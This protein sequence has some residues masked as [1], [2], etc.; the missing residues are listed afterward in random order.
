MM[1]FA[2]AVRKGFS[3]RECVYLINDQASTELS[4]HL[5]QSEIDALT[6]SLT[7]AQLMVGI[8]KVI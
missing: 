1:N 7:P 8:R 5:T 4:R 3:K 6:R 2:D